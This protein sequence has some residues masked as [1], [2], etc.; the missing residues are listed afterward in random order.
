MNWTQAMIQALM[1][2]NNLT[3][4]DVGLFFA[5]SFG[6]KIY[7]QKIY[8]NDSIGRRWNAWSWLNS[9]INDEIARE[10]RREMDSFY[11]EFGHDLVVVTYFSDCAPQCRP[12]QNR[13]YSRSGTNPKYPSLESATAE[14]NAGNGLYHYN[15]R[16]TT[17]P[18]VKGVI[19]PEKNVATEAEMDEAYKK[20]QFRSKSKSGLDGKKEPT[21]TDIDARL[22]KLKNN[23]SRVAK[24]ER[25]TLEELRDETER[26]RKKLEKVKNKNKK[27]Q[28]DLDNKKKKQKKD[29]QAELRRTKYKRSHLKI[30]QENM[31]PI[32]DQ[33]IELLKQRLSSL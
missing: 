17:H 14:H 28:E 9:Y 19:E 1:R 11:D 21:S 4:W 23:T 13:V 26:L 20:S 25:D 27:M 30:G 18:Y 31:V 3:I 12:W 5:E 7:D 15:C 32:L 33:K 2:Q 8:F 29:L 16:H 22:D 6:E 24:A 10:T